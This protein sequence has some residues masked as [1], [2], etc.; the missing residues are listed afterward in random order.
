MAISDALI[1]IRRNAK[2]SQE[3]FAHVFGVTRQAVQKWE[4]GTAIP[5]ITK[6]VEI[7]KSY[8]ISLDAILLNQDSRTVEKNSYHRELKPMYTDIHAWEFYASAAD[9]EYK[10]CLDEGLDVSQYANLFAAV[11]ALPNGEIKKDLGDVLFKIVTNAQMRPDYRYSEPSDLK[12]IQ[13]L[14]KNPA[15]K[16]KVDDK[17]ALESKIE[18]AWI[19]RVIGCML[20]T[21]IEGIHTNEL[22]P[23]LKK[24]G[25]YPL[26]RYLLRSDFND[27][28]YKEITFPLKCGR[29]ADEI[30][31]MPADDDT[32]YTVLYQELIEKFGRDFTPKDV[33]AMWLKSQPKNA[34]CTAERV[35]FINFVNGY[36][37]PDSAVYKNPYR[38]WIGA[39]IRG[40][41]F[42]Y[43]NPGDP[44]TAA[45]MAWRDASISH[46]KNGIYGEM[47]VAAML[48][49]AAVNTNIEEVILAGLSQIPHTSRLYESIT[50]IMTEFKNGT[51]KDDVFALIHKE[52]D[53]YTGYGWCHTISNAM[54]VTASLLYG[55]GDFEKSICMA[56]EAAFDTDCNGATVGSILGMT[57]GIGHIP[58]KW[59]EPFC[60]KLNTSI[61][62]V[63]TVKVSDRAKM[64]LSHLKL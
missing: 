8:G 23:L 47:F 18:G 4:N 49:E 9:T 44:E 22:L 58:Q 3:E 52:Y 61:F 6:L 25:N 50:K 16:K 43:I 34:Y 33:A 20:G 48:A 53:E 1:K 42:G 24:T 17:K 27:E 11:N 62:G 41:Y 38:E 37:P 28:I 39:Q 10:Q 32:N 7:S 26:H 40:D 45:E 30:D 55:K 54:I 12:G 14:R 36:N 31:G 19:G 5:E 46:V 60:D 2:L 29:F 51:A 35:A 21:S 64:T 15:K 13:A 57:F 59:Q 56:V 63:G